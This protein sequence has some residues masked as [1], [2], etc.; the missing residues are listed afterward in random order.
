MRIWKFPLAV[1][2]QQL[3]EIPR[4]AK[5]LTAQIQYGDKLNLWALVDEHAPKGRRLIAI[6]GTGNP[7]PDEGFDFGRYIATFQIAQGALVFHVFDHG[8]RP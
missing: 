6:Y 4:G 2:D 8:E 3:I 5:L 7:L 1:A